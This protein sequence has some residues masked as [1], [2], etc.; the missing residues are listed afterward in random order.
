MG[1]STPRVTIGPECIAL[2]VEHAITARRPRARYVAPW[3]ARSF[4]FLA[5]A[6]PTSWLDALFAWG[7]TKLGRRARAT[8]G[9]RPASALPG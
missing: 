7:L 1:I 6:L 4:L 8:E 2:A 3:S 9:M 5:S